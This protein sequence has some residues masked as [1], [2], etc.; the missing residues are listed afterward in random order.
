M[1]KQFQSIFLKRNRKKHISTWLCCLIFV[2]TPPALTSCAFPNMLTENTHQ[3]DLL[4]TDYVPNN[5]MANAIVVKGTEIIPS[6]TPTLSFDD[7]GTTFVYEG[8]Q[9]DVSD[10]ADE[11]DCIRDVEETEEY[12]IIR[13]HCP[14][15]HLWSCY[16]LFRKESKSFE[17]KYIGDNLIIVDDTIYYTL[18]NDILD[19]EE[20][21]IAK[22]NLQEHE[23]ITKLKKM[24]NKDQ[25]KVRI[26]DDRYE[27]EKIRTELVDIV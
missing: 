12:L 2:S 1:K 4:D 7:Q 6:P 10:F 18:W 19:G 17:K 13:G 26:W 20:N 16:A 9:Y 24:K 23:W 25:F 15:A 27:D 22:V 14:T 8:E 21:V 5:N 11:M 3:G